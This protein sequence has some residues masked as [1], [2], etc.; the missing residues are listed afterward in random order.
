MSTNCPNVSVQIPT[1]NLSKTYK[2]ETITTVAIVQSN[3]Q[4]IKSR[5]K[6]SITWTPGAL[7]STFIVAEQYRTVPR[8]EDNCERESSREEVPDG[9]IYRYRTCIGKSE[10]ELF[11]VP[12]DWFA[13]P[14]PLTAS[15]HPIPFFTILQFYRLSMIFTVCFLLL[16][17][18]PVHLCQFF[19]IQLSVSA[20]IVEF[21]LFSRS[22]YPY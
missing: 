19:S 6:W 17:L 15:I 11:Y 9:L 21:I 10:F 20:P 8:E 3:F 4:T 16:L 13:M 18:P 1:F 14:Q 12:L 5:R 7:T 2:R 22:Q